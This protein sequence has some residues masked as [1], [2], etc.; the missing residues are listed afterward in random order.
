MAGVN[1]SRQMALA[2]DAS[3]GHMREAVALQTASAYMDALLAERGLELARRARDT[4]NATLTRRR[5][6]STRACWWRAISCSRSV[7]LGRMEEKL[8]AAENGVQLTRARLFQWMGADQSSAY[9]R[10]IRTW[11][12]SRFASRHVGRRLRGR[13]P[14]PPRRARHPRRKCAPPSNGIQ[15]AQRRL[16]ARARARRPLQFERRQDLRVQ[17]RELRADGDGEMERARL[18]Q[19][20]AQVGGAKA[21]YAVAEQGAART[22]SRWRWKCARRG[23]RRRRRKPAWASRRVRPARPS[24]RFLL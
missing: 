9:S 17:R 16:L 4:T 7:Q 21:R 22:C 2:A 11:A 8:I 1:A 23:S 12:P 6:S 3:H 14:A 20:R 19:T 5:I 18:G 24:A 15:G 13:A 10:S